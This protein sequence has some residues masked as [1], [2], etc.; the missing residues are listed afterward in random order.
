[1]LPKS[2][3]LSKEREIKR[4]IRAKQYEARRPLL[5][6]VAMDN[7]HAESR[8][9]VVIPK[10]LGKAVVRNRMRRVIQAVFGNIRHKIAKNID[11]VVFPR[12]AA[13]GAESRSVESELGKCLDTIEQLNNEAIS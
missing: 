9:T 12:H 13:V 10:K 2:A 1:M 11:I 7:S 8:L 3:R 6:L 4:T 5:Y